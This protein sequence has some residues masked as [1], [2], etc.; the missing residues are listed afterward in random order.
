VTII[1]SFITSSSTLSMWSNPNSTS[2]LQF[3]PSLHIW[4]M[5]QQQWISQHFLIPNHSVLHN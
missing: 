5:L 3:S 2:S 1:T 4:P